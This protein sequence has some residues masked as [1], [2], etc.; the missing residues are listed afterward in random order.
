[1][2]GNQ[3][4]TN[5]QSLLRVLYFQGRID[6]DSMLFDQNFIYFYNQT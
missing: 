1:M 6:S 5:P 2:Q 4:N 3:W